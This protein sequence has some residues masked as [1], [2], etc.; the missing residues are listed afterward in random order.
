MYTIIARG[1]T[2]REELAAA[3]GCAGRIW[4]EG[5][6]PGYDGHGVVVW[7]EPPRAYLTYVDG[8]LFYVEHNADNLLAELFFRAC[9]KGENDPQYQGWASRRDAAR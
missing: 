3:T 9:G 4:P 5:R 8:Q 1:M 7:E 2:T 6:V